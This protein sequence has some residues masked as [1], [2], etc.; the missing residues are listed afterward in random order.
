MYVIV[1]RYDVKPERESD[2]VRDY[3][4]NGLWV[5]FF[6]S[7][8]GYLGT[9]LLQDADVQHRYLTIDRWT[10]RQ[11]YESFLAQRLEEYEA[12]DQGCAEMTNEEVRVGALETM[13]ESILERDEGGSDPA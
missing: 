3:G 2:F 6:G 10:N 12:L 4:P 7:G 8:A 5:G 1:W 11:A 9:E 13:D